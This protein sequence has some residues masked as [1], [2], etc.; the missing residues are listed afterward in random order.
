[1]VQQQHHQHELGDGAQQQ[2]AGKEPVTEPAA[3]AVTNRR[4]D[5]RTAKIRSW[6]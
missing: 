6:L 4:F 2:P 1:M 5:A 3:I